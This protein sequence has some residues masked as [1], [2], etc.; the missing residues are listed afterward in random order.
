MVFNYFVSVDF[1]SY[2]NIILSC[3]CRSRAVL[4]AL[5]KNGHNITAISPDIDRSP[6]PEVHYIQI[7]GTHETGIG[8]FVKALQNT[9]DRM[10]P[11]LEVPFIFKS[12]EIICAG[13]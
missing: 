7:K 9:T 2:H 5:A 11:L 12:C 10:N 4:N 3:Y 8:K 6:P 13:N 1:V